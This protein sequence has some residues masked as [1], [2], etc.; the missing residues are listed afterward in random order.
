M[1]GDRIINAAARL[2]ARLGGAAILASA[3][4]VGLE[5]ASRNFGLGLRLHAF[6]LTNYCLSP[7]DMGHH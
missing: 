1:T 4:L 3:L 5:V 7:L 6:E 2:S